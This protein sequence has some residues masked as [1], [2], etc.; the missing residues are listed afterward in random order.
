MKMVGYKAN[1]DNAYLIEIFGG[2]KLT[3]V[4]DKCFPLEKTAD[5]FRYFGEG[6]FRGK[7]VIIIDHNKK[8]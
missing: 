3:P 6:R 5:A 1:K 2:G 4:I 8:T 7:I